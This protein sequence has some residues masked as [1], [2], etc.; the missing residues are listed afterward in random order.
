[1]AAVLAFAKP[2]TTGIDGAG[3]TGGEPSRGWPTRGPPLILRASETGGISVFGERT[4][5]AEEEDA[6]Q[7][8]RGSSS[9]FSLYPLALVA[10]FGENTT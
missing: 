1:M 7:P 8:G 5:G 3:G 2:E 10:V 6:T 4:K 9:R